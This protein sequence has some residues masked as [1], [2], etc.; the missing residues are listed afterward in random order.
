MTSSFKKLLLAQTVA[1]SADIF[2]RVAIISNIYSISGSALAA[3]TVPI[4]I[5]IMMFIASFITP[6]ITKKISLN[7]IL[8]FTQLFKTILL[9]N[10]LFNAHSLERIP[11]MTLYII[12]G[13][14]SFFDGFASPVSHA[15]IP[16]YSEKLSEA[17]SLLN[18]FSETVQI[19]GWG[20]GGI[21]LINLGFTNTIIL[22]LFLFIFSTFVMFFLP[23]IPLKTLENETTLNSLKKGWQLFFIHKKLRLIMFLE[24]F[25]VLA[26]TIWVSSIMLVYVTEILKKNEIMWSFANT[27]YS[28][29]IIAGGILVYRFAKIISRNKARSMVIS[30]LGSALLTFVLL[31]W[32][33]SITFLLITLFIGFFSQLKGIP[34]TVILQESVDK[35]ALINIYSVFEV[36]GALS[37]SLFVFFMSTLTEIFGVVFVF[38]LSATLLLIEGILVLVNKSILN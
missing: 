6:L 13:G 24:L 32:D 9:F 37:F 38:M 16:W 14:I 15:V 26:G 36:V 2:L 18:I 1:N 17:N 28:I 33:N 4:I 20:L 22:T 29:G 7:R 11:A 31:V 35:Q 34:E 19:V 12:I 25:E 21:I 8:F 10:L 27:F 3:S 5:G 23:N 30:L